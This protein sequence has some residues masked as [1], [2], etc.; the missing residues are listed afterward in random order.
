MI[1]FRGTK[2]GVSLLIAIMLIGVIS[3]I[4]LSMTNAVVEATRRAA[5][6]NRY[7]EAY[8]LAE[9]ALEEGL[10]INSEHGAGYSDSIQHNFGS[11]KTSAVKIQ[12]QVPASAKYG[13]QSTYHDMYGAPA[14][15]TGNVG[16][17][18]DPLKAFKNM[19]F[20]YTA[21]GTPHYVEGT[22]QPQDGKTWSGPFDAAD[23]PCNWN[24]IKIGGTVSIPLYYS[25][26]DSSLGCPADPAYPGSYVCNLV[27]NSQSDAF[28]LRVRTPCKSNYGKDEMCLA[29]DRFDFDTDNVDPTYGQ[30]EPIMSW[31]ITGVDQTTNA[32]LVLGPYI[33]TN[34][35]KNLDFFST[36]VHEFILNYSNQNV[37]QLFEV[38]N[39]S[40]NGTDLNKCT[41]TVLNYLVNQPASCTAWGTNQIIKPILKLSVIQSMKSTPAQKTIPY[42]EYQ[43]LSNFASGM[44]PAD[45]SQTITSEGFSGEFKATIEARKSQSGGLIE[46]VVQ[47]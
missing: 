29:M 40:S 42:L 35:I 24:K 38:L 19:N 37:T 7:N 33:F 8:Y 14:P 23:H 6:S 18:C 25:T 10:L 13:N 47:Q 39:Q 32:S 3:Y 20:W 22:S 21:D 27:T 36:L 31:Q 41:D 28:I 34:I 4:S 26:T 15:G 46:Y 5:N 12:G 43:L 44:P 45:T 17:D 11:G 16:K 1:S 2:K 30:N 9:G